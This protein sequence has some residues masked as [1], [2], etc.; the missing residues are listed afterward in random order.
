MDKI[1]GT[2]VYVCIPKAVKAMEKN[3]V[4]KPDEWKASVVVDEDTADAFEEYG[5]QCK[6][7]VSCKKVKIAEFEA[8]YKCSP[9]E[10]AGKNVW[11]ITLRKST[12]LGKTGKPV[13]D[14]YQPKVFEKIGR[15]VVEITNSKLVG[16]GSKGTISIDPFTRSDGS[17][18]LFL[19]NVLVTDLVEYVPVERD[20]GPAGSEFNE[21]DDDGDTP[22]LAPQATGTKQRAKPT[23]PDLADMEDD[24][25]F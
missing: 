24:I 3:G 21:N 6:T 16:N 1:T 25:P 10:G 15:N 23:K 9:P 4:K 18:T 5:T 2:L 22:A 11:V 20:T 13:P 12:E 17:V 19:K 8:K 7:M 14:Q